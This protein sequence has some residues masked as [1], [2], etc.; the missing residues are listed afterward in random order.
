MVE[1][2]HDGGGTE[3]EPAGAGGDVG[4]EDGGRGED[5]EATEVVLGHPRAVEAHRL[6]L[7]ALLG[8]LAQKL[9][10]IAPACPVSRRVVG[11][12]EVTELHFGALLT[13]PTSLSSRYRTAW[14]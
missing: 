8:Y 14:P 6:G 7:D 1:R 10:G 4:K 5:P 2:Q 12:R 13:S 11:Q 3:L 9:V